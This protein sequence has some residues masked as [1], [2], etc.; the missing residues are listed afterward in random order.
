MEFFTVESEL[1]VMYKVRSCPDVSN[2]RLI[3][4]FGTSVIAIGSNDRDTSLEA[5]KALL[6]S[7]SACTT[8]YWAPNGLVRTST[9]QRGNGSIGM[10]KATI[11]ETAKWLRSEAGASS[12]PGHLAITDVAAAKD[13]F[14]SLAMPNTSSSL[15]PSSPA[16]P[17]G[18]PLNWSTGGKCR[19]LTDALAETP[20]RF[21]DLN[22]QARV[23]YDDSTRL[24]NCLMLASGKQ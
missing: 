1:R 16:N 11:V 18:L 23:V 7:T 6:H 10:S 9:P 4:Y 17:R 3:L 21:R 24:N 13:V 15:S 22:Q 20:R 14:V 8:P 5:T 2:R 12:W 19:L